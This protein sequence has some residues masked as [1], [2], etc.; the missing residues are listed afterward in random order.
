ML[1]V[2][3]LHVREKLEPLPPPYQFAGP[4]LP[5]SLPGNSPTDPRRLI[6]RLNNTVRGLATSAALARPANRDV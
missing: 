1:D 5:C 6:L 3:L 4:S 2:Q